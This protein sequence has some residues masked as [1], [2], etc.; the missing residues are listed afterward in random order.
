MEQGEG[1]GAQFEYAIGVCEGR[2]GSW[3]IDDEAQGR[4]DAWFKDFQRSKRTYPWCYEGTI[5]GEQTTS[6]K[7]WAYLQNPEEKQEDEKHK[8]SLFVPLADTQSLIDLSPHREDLWEKMTRYT[9]CGEVGFY[10]RKF[11]HTFKQNK[12]A[13]M[14]RTFVVLYGKV[15]KMLQ[16]RKCD[17]LYR[18]YDV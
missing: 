2:E 9:S 8:N 11:C 14:D 12:H 4:V 10:G 5:T 6:R 17:Y 3:E 7:A 13:C 1:S 18:I 15:R 16:Y